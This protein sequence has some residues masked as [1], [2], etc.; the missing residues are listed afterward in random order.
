MFK[1]SK[2][3]SQNHLH[4]NFPCLNNYYKKIIDMLIFLVFKVMQLNFFLITQIYFI[5]WDVGLEILINF[6]TT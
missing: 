4:F 1:R 6:T 3:L 5:I 2:F